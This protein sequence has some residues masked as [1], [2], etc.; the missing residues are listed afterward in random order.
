MSLPI[1]PPAR[2]VKPLTAADF[3]AAAGRIGCDVAAVRAVCAVESVSSGFFPN[4]EPKTL[5]EGHKFY[6]YTK[7]AHAETAPD[8]CYPKWTRE[9]YGATWSAEFDRL[10]R[11]V[12]LDRRAAYLSTSWGRFQIMGFNYAQAGFRDL[13]AFVEAM[14]ES[15]GRQLLAFVD[16]VIVSGLGDELRDCRWV[17]FARRYNGPGYAA[18]QYDK[19][20]AAEYAK[21]GGKS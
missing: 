19:K 2:D 4:G 20:L 14:R 18:N 13:F 11:A 17:D 7:G 9:F 5:F 16:Y 1:T 10:Q 6:L 3:K 15:E 8:L 12:A 21:A